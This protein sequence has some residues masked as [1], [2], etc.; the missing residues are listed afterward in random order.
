MKRNSIVLLFSLVSLMMVS[1]SKTGSIF[2]NGEPVTQE[3]PIDEWFNAVRIHNNVNVELIQS[4]NPHIEITCP[5]NLIDRITTVVEDSTLVVRNENTFNWLRSF[6]YECNMKVYYDSLYELEYASIG[7]LISHDTLRGC[8]EIN[9]DSTGSVATR[10]FYLRI[11]EGC[12]KVD[13]TFKCDVLKDRFSNGTSEVWLRGNVNYSEHI[14]SSYGSL[15]AEELYSDFVR[16]QS[17]STNDAY[18]WGRTKL[19][20]WI[21]TIGNVYYKGHPYV[22]KHINGDGDVFPME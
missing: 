7:D 4:N 6:D 19:T 11:T 14:L 10:A 3:R 9:T 8:T 22:E 18:V 17:N 21:S 20:V 15:H 2:S 1:C 16:V 5:E 12:G 13:L